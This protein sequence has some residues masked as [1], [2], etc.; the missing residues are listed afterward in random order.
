MCF[1]NSLRL[2]AVWGFFL[3]FV[4]VALAIP[5]TELRSMEA[6]VKAT[7]AQGQTPVLVFDLDETLIDST[8]RKYMAF[9]DAIRELCGEVRYDYDYSWP[10]GCDRAVT[11]HQSEIYALPN[12]YN[13]LSFFDSIY[14]WDDWKKQLDDRMIGIYSSGKRLDLDREIPG[15]ANFVKRMRSLGA[16]FYFVS[17]RNHSS[18]RVGTLASLRALGFGDSALEQEVILKPE[19]MRSLEFKQKTFAMIHQQPGKVVGVFENEPEN[20]NAMIT[21]FPDALA[22]FI[23]GAWLIDLPVSPKAIQLNDYY[24]F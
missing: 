19:G 3:S 21:E 2:F 24:T 17:S 6:R 4:P 15:A 20:M 23:R 7:V 13:I 18:Q 14:T 22:Y 8:P 5:Q 9:R 12:R 16:K 1:I 11:V 10:A